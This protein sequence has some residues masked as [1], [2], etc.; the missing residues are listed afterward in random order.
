VNV[1]TVF[2]KSSLVVL[3]TEHCG[4]LYAPRV[5]SK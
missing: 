3:K 1:K 5:F 2:W 4:L